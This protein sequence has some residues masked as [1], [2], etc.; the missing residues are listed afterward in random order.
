MMHGPINISNELQFNIFYA[1]KG[2][3]MFSRL[4]TLF[5]LN[6]VTETVR[7]TED[8]MLAS[9][10]LVDAYRYSAEC[11]ASVFMALVYGRVA[12]CPDMP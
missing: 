11:A 8:S 12:S 2:P 1:K 5:L 3:I 10:A 4:L 9:P 6:C 7:V